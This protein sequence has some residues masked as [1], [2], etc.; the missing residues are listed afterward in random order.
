MKTG[1]THFKSLVFAT[2]VALATPVVSVDAQQV[3]IPTTAAKVPGPSPGT[4]I[5]KEYVQM[6][7][8][9]AYIWGWALIDN[10]NRHAAFSKAPEPGLLGGVLPI[11]HNSLAMLN[12]YVSP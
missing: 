8:R 5:T 1:A 4:R 11:S 7:G 12:N 3:P 9:M 6:V 10:A 2:V